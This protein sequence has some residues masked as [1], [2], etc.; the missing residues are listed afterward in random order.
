MISIAGNL[1]LI[2]LYLKFLGA[3]LYGYWLATG[4]ILAWLGLFDFGVAGIMKQRCSHAYGEKD[5]EKACGY[6][7]HGMLAYMAMTG[8]ILVACF[9]LSYAIGPI[10]R[11]PFETR[12]VI[13]HCFLLAG[14]GLVTSVMRDGLVS[15]SQAVQRPQLTMYTSVAAQLLHFGVCLW[16]ILAGWGL[17]SIP[18]GLIARNL[19]GNTYIAIR[20]IG[21]FRAMGG[22]LKLDR[23]IVK[24]YLKI[25]PVLVFSRLGSQS[26]AR[27][28]PALITLFLRPEL[29][30]AY[31]I[32]KKLAEIM[33]GFVSSIRGAVLPGFAHL[34]AQQKE[35]RTQAIYRTLVDAVLWGTIASLAVYI[36][37]NKVFIGMWVGPAQFAGT[38]LT[39]LIAVSVLATNLMGTESE[40]YAATGAMG[41]S[42][43]ALTIESFVRMGSMAALLPMLNLKGLPLAAIIS[44]TVAFAFFKSR[45][46]AAIGLRTQ[47]FAIGNIKYLVGGGILVLAALA[48]FG[49]WSHSLALTV[50]QTLF[51][52]S[53]SCSAAITMSQELRTEIR[54]MV[55]FLAR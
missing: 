44:S 11:I 22:K 2:P 36:C 3:G 46:R 37:T 48:S 14:V 43:V 7:S 47:W 16:L 29:A 6:F 45:T 41:T 26:L 39:V 49:P 34:Y 51:V 27:I 31:V 19:A 42:S 53:V 32:T 13:R 38:G 21:L 9:S 5:Y 12:T 52:F 33:Q 17:Y 15:F 50:A 4:G 10:F 1:V 23:A 20:A 24:D 30:T 8:I 55:P 28:E 54:R 18:V 25:G 35:A 40:L